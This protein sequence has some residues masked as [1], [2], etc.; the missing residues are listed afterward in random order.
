[1]EKVGIFYGHLE[2]V[3]V[4]WYIFW[5]L[6]IWGIIRCIYIFPFWSV[7]L[8]IIWQ[9]WF[10]QEPKNVA[11]H[12]IAKPNALKVDLSTGSLRNVEGSH[13]VPAVN[14]VLGKWKHYQQG[15]SDRDAR[16]FLVQ[17]TKTG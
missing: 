15:V 7:A 12:L 10:A 5:L 6:S 9:P 4:I 14:D 11:P 17:N 1:M 3:M 8:R 2:N 16:F 13:L